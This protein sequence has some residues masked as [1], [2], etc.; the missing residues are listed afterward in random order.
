MTKEAKKG[1]FYIGMKLKDSNTAII[2]SVGEDGLKVAGYSGKGQKRRCTD[3]YYDEQSAAAIA[4]KEL[5]RRL[6]E[7]FLKLSW[8]PGDP[9]ILSLSR[10]KVTIRLIRVPAQLP[11]EI[12]KIVNFQAPRYLPY[13]AEELISAFQV[14]A[15]EGQGYSL[16]SI[17]IAHR[18]TIE[19]FIRVF[20][21]LKAE[22]VCIAVSS[23]SFLYLYNY[24]RGS[25]PQTT[26]LLD[27]GKKYSELVIISRGKLLYSRYLKFDAGRPGL[28]ATLSNEIN[29]TQEAFV[30]ETA[31]S[32]PQKLIIFS[33]AKGQMGSLAE[34]IGNNTGME[35][36]EL[37][38]LSARPFLEVAEKM[39]GYEHSFVDMLGFVLGET[40][41][42]L[43]LLPSEIKEKKHEK[44]V[45]REYTRSAVLLLVASALFF[46]GLN[47]N[48]ANKS[49]YLS[50]L[51]KQLEQYSA[52]AGYLESMEK[53][54][55]AASSRASKKFLSLDILSA[56][57]EVVPENVSFT[58]IA[59]GETGP[60]VLK[61]QASEINSVFSLAGQLEKSEVFRDY[62]IKV[63]YVSKKQ[64]GAGEAVNFEIACE[65]K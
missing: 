32:R 44:A 45:R 63:K 42:S 29:R 37:L 24:L 60:I 23:Y 39:Y 46:F 59:Y 48:L 47:R 8:R 3:V 64:S 57:Y 53:R 12:E 21:E 56:L 30:K 62:S 27:I 33:K 22:N 41:I 50:G 1:N 16:V 49:Q 6:S 7:V 36:E 10:S 28:E 25:S 52:Q 40:E 51:E 26:M 31:F 14:V 58:K 13:P 17:V 2:C 65:K 18:E 34:S 11:A 5:S 15:Y 55:R 4:D 54:L 43:N 35:V 61:G 38:Y 9:V 20:S 19:R